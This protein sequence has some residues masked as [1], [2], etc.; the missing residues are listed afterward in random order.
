MRAAEIIDRTNSLYSIFKH[1]IR[2]NERRFED[3]DIDTVADILIT[4]AGVDHSTIARP[5]LIEHIRLYCDWIKENN[6]I[7]TGIYY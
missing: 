5:Q 3:M 1:T 6:G 7:D 4:T 2:L